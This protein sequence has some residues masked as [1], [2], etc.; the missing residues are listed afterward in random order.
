MRNRI[1]KLIC[2][3]ELL[4]TLRDRRTLFVALILPLLLYPA[5][6]IGMTQIISVT[7]SN[8]SQKSQRIL[9]DGD[10]STVKLEDLLRGAMA[11]W[12]ATKAKTGSSH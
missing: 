1:V 10:E 11:V 9:L 7:Q 3:K 12:D 8:L 4:D 5:L 6:L 2:K